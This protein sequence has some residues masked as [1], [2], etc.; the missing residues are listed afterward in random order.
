MMKAPKK[1]GSEEEARKFVR[2]CEDEFEERLELA[3]NRVCETGDIRII[4]LA[5]P[6]CSGKTTAARKLIQNLSARGKKVH[7]VS[8]DDFYYDR[9]VLRAMADAQDDVEI[10]YDSEDTIDFD[11]LRRCV[12]QICTD[13]PTELPVFDFLEGKRNGHRIIDSDPEDIFIF[14]GIQAIYPK[15]TA[16]FEEYGYLSVYIS[17][18]TEIDVDG[19][20]FDQNEI[21]LMRRIV[22]DYQFRGATPEFTLFLWDSVRTNEELSIFPYAVGCDS[23]INSALQCEIGLLK[24]FLEK[25]LPQIPTDDR[26]R[27]VA[28]KILNKIRDIEAIPAAY[29]SENSLYF[30][31]I[32]K[33][34]DLKS[35][36]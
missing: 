1:F 8:I 5:G 18:E 32:K 27:A 16:L 9:D 30:E 2:L 33:G 34:N 7:V 15:V 12:A 6:T 13:E 19:T 17:V 11:E 22:R 14:E 24:P 23:F 10:D 31:F 36:V 25:I 35:R 28:D 3:V 21:R 20:V 4:A 26:K 29:L